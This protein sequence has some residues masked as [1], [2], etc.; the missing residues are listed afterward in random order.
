MSFTEPAYALPIVIGSGVT[1]TV[2]MNTGAGDFVSTLTPGTYYNHTIGSGSFALMVETQLNAADT[3]SPWAVSTPSTGLSFRLK[4]VRTGASTDEMTSVTFSDDALRQ[5]MGFSV[6]VVT[7]GTEL[8]NDT[9][10]TDDTTLEGS[11]QRGFLWVPRSILTRDE[12]IPLA[13]V[14]GT[15]TPVGRAVLDGYGQYERI[16]HVI[17]FVEGPLVYTDKAANADFQNVQVPGLALGDDTAPL[18]QFWRLCRVGADG[19][20]PIIKYLVDSTDTAT[21]EDIV[22]ADVSWLTD[23]D[24][25]VEEMSPSPLLYRVRIDAMESVGTSFVSTGPTIGTSTPGVL[26]EY[27]T[28]NDLPTAKNGN[29]GSF[30]DGLFASVTTTNAAGVYTYMDEIDGFTVDWWLPSDIVAVGLTYVLNAGG[31]PYRAALDEGENKATLTGRGWVETVTGSSTITDITDA[32]KLDSPGSPGQ[33][34]DIAFT[35]VAFSSTKARV[36]FVCRVDAQPAVS[37]GV[38]QSTLIFYD[39]IRRHSV[40]Q[41]ANGVANRWSWQSGSS[42]S[43]LAGHG[44][45]SVGSFELMIGE[46][47]LGTNTVPDP[48]IALFWSLESGWNPSL[49][50]A[51]TRDITTLPGAGGLTLGSLFCRSTAVGG[52]RADWRACHMFHIGDGS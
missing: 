34:A 12:R 5:A 31:D 41:V 13:Q 49:G 27:D 21:T 51:M 22:I 17:E 3:G 37:T 2:D 46:I 50:K 11:F 48:D 18:D 28:Y 14:A 26:D 23:M 8:A 19:A 32:L 24:N 6:L 45:A 35:P 42:G 33:F 36:L 40:T 20:P 25:V 1:I 29:T 44:T 10:T 16:R 43:G 38:D 15:I 9:P 4:F 47:E 52:C 7:A 30:S 39:G